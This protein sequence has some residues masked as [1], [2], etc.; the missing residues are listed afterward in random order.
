MDFFSDGTLCLEVGGQ[1]KQ[2]LIQVG[3]GGRLE[4]SLDEVAGDEF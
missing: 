3:G 4:T 2:D 1:T